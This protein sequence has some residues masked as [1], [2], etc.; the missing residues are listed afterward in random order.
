[1]SN[2]IEQLRSLARFEHAD[3]S[4]GDEAAQALELA[5]V[6]EEE[7][8]KRTLLAERRL[9]VATEALEIVA[10]KRQCI[11]NLMSNQDVANEAL[12]LIATPPASNDGCDA[13]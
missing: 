9:S 1:M 10:G 5:A 2:L 3:L 6:V 13:P 8:A 12:R 11:E 7:R 4:I